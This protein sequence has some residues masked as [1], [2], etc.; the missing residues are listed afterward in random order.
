MMKSNSPITN[1]D[2]AKRAH[3][4]WEDCGR[5]EGHETDHW[6]RAEQEL[7]KDRGQAEQFAQS[8]RASKA[9]RTAHA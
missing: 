4:I 9:S 2:I 7:R 5:L 1:E 8:T 6:F 3:D